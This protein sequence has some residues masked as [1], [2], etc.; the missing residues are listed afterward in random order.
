MKYLFVRSFIG[1]VLASTRLP[2]EIN[3]SSDEEAL[4]KSKD[5]GLGELFK[6]MTSFVEVKRGNGLHQK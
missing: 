4:E 5:L 1:E 2:V 3:A 6:K